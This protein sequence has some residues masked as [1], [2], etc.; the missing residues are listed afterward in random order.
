MT[1]IG[2]T[3]VVFIAIPDKV[4]GYCVAIIFA[5]LFSLDKNLLKKLT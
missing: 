3:N 4:I 1:N 2:S 5:G